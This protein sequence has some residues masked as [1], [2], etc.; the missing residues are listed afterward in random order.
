MQLEDV[1]EEPCLNVVQF[2]APMLK[3]AVNRTVVVVQ[4]FT[5]W[6]L[7]KQRLW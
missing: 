5:P 1:A 3:Y 2:P 6:A 4:S 7:R